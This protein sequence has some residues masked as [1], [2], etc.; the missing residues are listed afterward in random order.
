[1]VALAV[2]C[3]NPD[4]PM[5]RLEG[6]WVVAL[7]AHRELMA[8]HGVDAPDFAS[9][10]EEKRIAEALGLTDEGLEKTGRDALALLESR[11]FD[12]KRI[13]KSAGENLDA[14]RANPSHSVGRPEDEVVAGRPA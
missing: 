10:L 7:E 2:S 5:A 12:T 8:A 3:N 6:L 9:P 4:V 1:M 13:L 11:G 14:W